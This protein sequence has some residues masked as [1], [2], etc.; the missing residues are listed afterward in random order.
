MAL[1]VITLETA[2]QY[3]HGRL[4]TNLITC[5]SECLIGL[6]VYLRANMHL[7]LWLLVMNQV[8]QNMMI[9]IAVIM[10]T[11]MSNNCLGYYNGMHV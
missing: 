2:V 1:L 5:S 9:F 7:F 11:D 4:A 3:R 10:I 8:M 6:E